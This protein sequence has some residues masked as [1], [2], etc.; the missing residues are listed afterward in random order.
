MPALLRAGA[1]VVVAEQELAHHLPAHAL[2]RGGGQH[3]LRRAARAHVDVDAGLRRLGAVDH[4]RHVAVGD[5]P[6]PRAGGADLGDQLLVPRPLEHADHHP[7]GAGALGAC[8]R[9]DALGRGHVEADAAPRDNPG[10]SRACPYR[11]RARAASSRAAPSRSPPARS[12]C[13]WRSGWCPP[14]GR[15]RCRR[16]GRCRCRPPRRCRASAPRRARPRRSPPRPGCRGGS[17]GCASRRRRPGRRPS[18]RRCRSAWPRR[19]RPAPTPGRGPSDSMRSAK[20]GSSDMARPPLGRRRASRRSGRRGKPVRLARSR[21][22]ARRGRPARAGA[23]SARV[24]P[25]P[26]LEADRGRAS[27][28]CGSPPGVQRDRGRCRCRRSRRAFAGSPAPRAR[29][30]RVS[31]RPRCPARSPGVDIDRV[32]TVKR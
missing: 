13:P 26:E 1:L 6:D 27:R 16:R 29:D 32:S 2:Q 24:E 19:S 14:A 22:G 31:S 20:I 11:R 4:A 12:A 8:E 23:A 9:R 5:Q 15:A 28:P 3:A 18:R 17:A 21:S 30:Q 7:L 10:R 25:A